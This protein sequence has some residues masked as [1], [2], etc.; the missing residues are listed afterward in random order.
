MAQGRVESER[1]LMKGAVSWLRE[2]RGCKGG[3]G[4]SRGGREQRAL[5]SHRSHGKTARG[6]EGRGQSIDHS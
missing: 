6:A 5:W 4:G 3:R 1:A 2:G